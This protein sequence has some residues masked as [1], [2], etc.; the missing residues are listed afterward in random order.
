MKKIYSSQA[1]F[2]LV[3]I[4]VAL[5]IG[6]IVILAGTQIF[7]SGNKTFYKGE[8]RSQIQMNLRVASTKITDTLRYAEVLELL[9]DDIDKRDQEI[10]EELVKAK[11]K[12]TGN[13]KLIYI[14][15]EGYIKDENKNKIMDIKVSNNIERSYFEEVEKIIKFKISDPSEDY[16]IESKVIPLN[17]ILDDD[18]D[19]CFGII[20][21]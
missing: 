13:I 20:Y 19:K 3:E 16:S 5:A 2:T 17:G 11:A 8:E 18:D 14:D 15:N 1:G 21:R 12:H 4:I 6:T 9:D 10:S 7:L